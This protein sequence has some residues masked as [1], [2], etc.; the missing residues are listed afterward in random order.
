M[1]AYVI[2]SRYFFPISAGK[3]RK[4]RLLQKYIETVQGIWICYTS[5]FGLHCVLLIYSFEDPDPD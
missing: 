5:T 3:V 4:F 2:H 1:G